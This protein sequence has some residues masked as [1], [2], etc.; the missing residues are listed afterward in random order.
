MV[1]QKRK[2]VPISVSVSTGANN[3][4]A[5][6]AGLQS[7]PKSK[8]VNDLLLM[9][10]DIPPQFTLTVLSVDPL[11]ITG[12]KWD[13]VLDGVVGVKFPNN[14]ADDTT[15]YPVL[16]FFKVRDTYEGFVARLQ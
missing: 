16:S 15:F 5:T 10:P 11:V 6:L 2:T 12:D 3:R 7:V 13:G 8:I 14:G 9:A 1:K 4:L